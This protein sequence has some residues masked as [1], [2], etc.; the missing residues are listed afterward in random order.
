MAKKKVNSVDTQSGDI[1][2]Q[3]SSGV[4]SEGSSSTE[5]QTL[6]SEIARLTQAKADI[7]A[8]IE[9]KGVT[10]GSG[11]IDTY[12]EKIGEISS[13]GSGGDEYSY[14]TQY[15][16]ESGLAELGWTQESINYFKYNN[17]INPSQQSTY[18]VSQANKDIY[19]VINSSNIS[20][21]KSNS[22]LMFL[23]YFD[24]SSV[25]AMYSKFSAFYSLVS[26]PLLN[27]SNVTDM[28]NMFSNCRS[29]V[30]IP[31]LYTSKATSMKYMFSYC[32][33]LAS[34]PLLDTSKV[35]SMYS[36]FQSCA[37]LV[38]I[39]LLNTS[40]VT[41]MSGMFSYCNSLK[42]I[43]LLNTSKVTNMSSMFENCAS[44]KTIPL[45]NTNNVTN[46]GNMFSY[47][48]SLKSVPLLNT[49]KVTNMNYMFRSCSLLTTL[50]GFTGL[51]TDLDL[52]YC[53]NLTHDSI[54][55]VINKAATVSSQTLTLGSTNLAKLTDEEKAIAT[56]KGWILK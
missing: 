14:R 19:G 3:A 23:P 9:A 39:P 29:L 54:L 41:N 4:T 53:A 18:T 47:C 16:D 2:V 51:K 32:Y 15:A 22:D 50:N 12:A 20:N 13:G 37:S 55:N 10:V 38:S 49:S 48:Y 5:G 35:N 26:I 25:T 44:L 31:P 33:S 17:Y 21:Y 8:A 30:S 1:A 6:S 42:S 45:L 11:T 36:M 34:I 56:N 46:M 40:N 52:S 27:T 7:K 28:S 24:T 43:P